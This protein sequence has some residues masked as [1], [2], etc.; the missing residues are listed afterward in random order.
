MGGE[1]LRKIKLVLIFYSW[2]LIE[3]LFILLNIN[4]R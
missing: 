3:K 4:T 2:K 1:G